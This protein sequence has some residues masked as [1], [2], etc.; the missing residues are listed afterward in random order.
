MSHYLQ[1]YNHY[2]I[3]THIIHTQ[4]IDSSVVFNI[5]RHSSWVLK[6]KQAD[7]FNGGYYHYHSRD[8][9]IPTA[10][11]IAWL[12]AHQCTYKYKGANEDAKTENQ[13]HSYL[14]Y[15]TNWHEKLLSINLA[16]TSLY[17]PKTFGRRLN[18]KGISCKIN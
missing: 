5:W 3:H 15:F 11:P 10:A 7:Y 17:N 8:I 13:M 2:I 4:M 14:P 12:L 16:S 1:I 18:K 9:L 6:S